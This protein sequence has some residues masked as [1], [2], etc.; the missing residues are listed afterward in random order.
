MV[1]QVALTIMAPINPGLKEDLRQ[2]LQAMGKDPANNDLLPFSKLSGTHFARLFILDEATDLNGAPIAP[3]LVYMSDVDSPLERHLDEL[4]GVT[5]AG[6][7]RLFS[8]CAGYPSEGLVT[9]GLRRVY[10]QAHAVSAAAVYVNTLGR[11]LQEIRQDAQLRDA[12]QGFLDESRQ[13][14]SG[15]DP[16]AIR[17]AIQKFVAGNASLGLVRT[18][19]PPFD[20]RWWLRETLG[21]V[22]TPLFLVIL[23]PLA[24]VALP[25]WLAVLRRLEQTDIPENAKP[26]AAWAEEL[27]NLEDYA[28]QNPFT[29]SGFVKPGLLRWLTMKLVLWLADYGTRHIFNRGDLAGVKTIHFARWVPIDGD[30]RVLFSSYY[31]GSLE[32]YMDDFIDKVAWGLNAVFSN[33]VGYPKTNWLVLDG[34]KDEQ[35]FKDYLRVHQTPTPVWYSAYDRLTALN[36]DKNAK[37]RAG[38]YGSLTESQVREW[39]GLL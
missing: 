16:A 38:L 2:L 36:I 1:D 26:S 23:S 8:H 37:I 7:D 10:L 28:A 27:A 39:L 13:D 29:A 11:T 24:L 21:L 3:Y 20:A 14:W 9:P 6:L 34:A 25:F 22:G 17:A 30:R 19:S 31:D 15:T 33:G 35:A 5:S 32:S 12:I 4:V 18:P